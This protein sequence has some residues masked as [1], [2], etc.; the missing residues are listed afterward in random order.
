MARAGAR[1]RDGDGGRGAVS[2]V[3]GPGRGG[4]AVRGGGAGSPSLSSSGGLG[5]AVAGRAADVAASPAVSIP[6]VVSGPD[7]SSPGA[8]IAAAPDFA[9]PAPDVV[10]VADVSPPLPA[11]G[12]NPAGIDWVRLSGGRY[13]TSSRRGV[14]DP[15]EH[16][17]HRVRVSSFEM[18]RTEVTNA[19]W[20]R[21][22]AAGGCSAAHA[23]DGSCY[24]RFGGRRLP[25]SFRG[26][27]QPAVGADRER[28]SWTSRRPAR[29][30]RGPRGVGGASVHLGGRGRDGVAGRG[31]AA[32]NQRR[33]GRAAPAGSSR[34]RRKTRLARSPDERYPRGRTLVQ[35]RGLLQLCARSCTD[36][37][38]CRTPEEYRAV[39]DG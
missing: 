24:V 32:A 16:P 11:A 9:A 25:G 30:G 39:K 26:D 38:R 36:F 35:R 1:R 14:G 21:C 3:R 6:D 17:R 27:R 4:D 28:G 22:L 20:R 2:G 29:E 12:A 7:L 19:Q 18:S 33:A 34:E 31:G 23:D 13:A 8:D 10:V 15:D 5:P 37:R